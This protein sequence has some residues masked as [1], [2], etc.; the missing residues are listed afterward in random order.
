MNALRTEDNR[1]APAVLALVPIVPE[2]RRYDVYLSRVLSPH[3]RALIASGFW[4]WHV[5]IGDR[6]V[7]SGFA[8]SEHQAERKAALAARRHARP[9]ARARH[10]P[11]RT[12]SINL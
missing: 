10:T 7:G 3:W 2:G 9:P 11:P 5:S 4:W 8:W 1:R 6:E 12:Y